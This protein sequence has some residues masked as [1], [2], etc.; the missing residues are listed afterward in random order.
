MSITPLLLF[1]HVDV[2]LGSSSG[3]LTLP[4]SVSEQGSMSTSQ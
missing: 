2:L 4:A 3:I 1:V